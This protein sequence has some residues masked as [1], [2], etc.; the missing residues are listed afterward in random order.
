MI[1]VSTGIASAISNNTASMISQLWEVFAVFFAI[2]I[3]FYIIRK[4]VFTFT[5]AK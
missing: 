4:I 5:L 2:I 1:N 3:T